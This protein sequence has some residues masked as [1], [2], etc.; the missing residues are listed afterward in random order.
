MKI[1]S[2]VVC[3][4]LSKI[5][6]MHLLWGLS[7]FSFFIFIFLKLSYNNARNKKLSKFSL[8]IVARKGT[9]AQLVVEWLLTVMN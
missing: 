7:L 6:L 1:I 2:L 5:N 9:V 8:N 3:A 4:R